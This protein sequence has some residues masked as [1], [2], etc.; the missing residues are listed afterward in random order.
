MGGIDSKSKSSPIKKNIFWN[1]G[2]NNNNYRKPSRDL[3]GS[4]LSFK[5]K[6][7]G[8]VGSR[9]TVDLVTQLM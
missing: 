7:R 2:H 8:R 5:V 3:S 4:S 9:S 1:L 6:I